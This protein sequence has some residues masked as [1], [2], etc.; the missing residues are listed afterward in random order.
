MLANYN[1][2]KIAESLESHL[3]HTIYVKDGTEEIFKY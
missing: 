3:K 1:S 2:R